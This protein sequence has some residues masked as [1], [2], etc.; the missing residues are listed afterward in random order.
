[1][2]ILQ[3]SQ[4]TKLNAES[5]NKKVSNKD[6]KIKNTDKNKIDIEISS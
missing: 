2:T 4:K 1:M 6:R 3:S 5:S